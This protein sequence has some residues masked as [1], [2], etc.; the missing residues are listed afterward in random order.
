MA[1]N[2]NL[3]PQAAQA[4]A[5]KYEAEAAAAQAAAA[6]AQNDKTAQMAIDQRDQMMTFM[7]QQ[8]AALR[9]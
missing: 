7:Q 4:L 5:K 3:T 2:P 9:D 6:Q 1:A 8:M